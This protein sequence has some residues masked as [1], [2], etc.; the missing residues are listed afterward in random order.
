MTAEVCGRS[1]RPR[2]VAPPLKSTR[3]KLSVSEEF[4]RAS[5]RTRVR[6]SSLL[7]EPVAPISIPCGP[8][9][10]W[11]DSLMSSSTGSPSA[12]TAI[13]TL[14][15]LGPVCC[16]SAF[17]SWRCRSGMPSSVVSSTLEESGSEESDAEPRPMRY[18]ASRLASDTAPVSPKVSGRPSRVTCSLR[19]R[20]VRTRPSS[21][22][23]TVKRRVM[24]P[25]R[26]ES[27]PLRSRTTVLRK[28][29]PS[30][31]W[32]A[33][34]TPPSTTITVNGSSRPGT[35]SGSNCGR[36]MN[37]APSRFSSSPH[38][39]TVIRVGPAPSVSCGWRLWG[40]HFVHS[41]SARRSSETQNAIHTSSGEWKVANWASS[42]RTRE[43]I[44]SSS[45]WN[46]TRAQARR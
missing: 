43:R 13:G 41:Q 25:G 29:G 21:S 18:G 1:S 37:S 38:A 28:P 34:T 46:S 27:A 14:S 23:S 16:H 6:S 32:P 40:S 33:G 12:P 3:M 4:V 31:R 9:P 42:A 11:A 20:S 44:R 7:P 35:A 8:V 26:Q 15:R 36:S 10:P 24:R 22:S 30:R 2:K 5:E 45:P 19:S 39:E 17:G